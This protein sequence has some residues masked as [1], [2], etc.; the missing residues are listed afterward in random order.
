MCWLKNRKSKDK[1]VFKFDVEI[2]QH[3]HSWLLS[4]SSEFQDVSFIPGAFIT[5]QPIV[6]E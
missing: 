4:F 6:Q 5:S 1:S 2:Q 3:H